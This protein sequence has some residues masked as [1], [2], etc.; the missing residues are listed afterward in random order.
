MLDIFV[1]FVLYVLVWALCSGLIV[2]CLWLFGICC[3][4]FDLLCYMC[5]EL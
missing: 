2:S 4:V 3:F 5:A 1:S